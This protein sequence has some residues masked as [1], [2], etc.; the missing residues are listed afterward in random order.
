MATLTDAQKIVKYRSQAEDKTIPQ[1]ARNKLLDRANELEYKAFEGEKKM[2][3]GGAVAKKKPIMEY[4]GKEK[5][6][7]KAAMAKHEKGEGKAMEKKEKM[8]S[9]GKPAGVAILI[10]PVKKLA[11]GGAVKPMAKKK[12]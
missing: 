11:K 9:K 4:G 5:Y 8:M 1:D 3:K 6:A 2:A 7:S 12:C 10:S